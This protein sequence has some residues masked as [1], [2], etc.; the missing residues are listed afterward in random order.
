MAMIKGYS[1][2]KYILSTVRVCGNCKYYVQHYSEVDNHI[3][4][5]IFFG[6]CKLRAEKAKKP[7]EKC[8]SF[9]MKG[10]EE[11]V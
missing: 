6:H 7:S 8:N 9:V 5:P 3:C 2:Y 1:D 11:D 4:I 10:E